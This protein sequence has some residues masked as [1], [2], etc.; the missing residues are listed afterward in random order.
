MVFSPICLFILTF[1][2]STITIMSLY[3]GEFQTVQYMGYYNFIMAEGH[4]NYRDNSDVLV[5]Y[6]RI[7]NH[8]TR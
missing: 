6:N 4:A 8:F 2:V 7:Y 5:T 1:L 3:V